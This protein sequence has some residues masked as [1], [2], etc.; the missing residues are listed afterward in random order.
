[1]PSAQP[2]AGRRP[3]RR[4]NLA[5]T[6]EKIVG[7][8]EQLFATQGYT[9]TGLREIAERAGVAVSL[10]PQ[11][12]GSKAELFEA[13]L[14]EAMRNNDV[15]EVADADIARSLIEHGLNDDD[16]SLPAMIILSIG[17]PDASE[18][19]GR[20]LR[21]EIVTKLAKRLGPPDARARAMEM[22]ML[23]TGFLIYG[24]QLPAGPVSAR[25]KR[26]IVRALQ[27]IVDEG[28]VR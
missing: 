16:I 25:T 24:R 20:V 7:A 9:H 12:F 27:A 10:L 13:A 22:I 21:D 28:K 15:L 3:K 5:K 23:S 26:N 17:D 8:A 6:K 2:A 11:H 18:I 19:A 4:R 14:S 1:M